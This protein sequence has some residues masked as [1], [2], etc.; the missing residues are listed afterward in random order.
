MD[1]MLPGSDTLEFDGSIILHEDGTL[2]AYIKLGKGERVTWECY[3]FEGTCYTD[4]VEQDGVT[5]MTQL[6]ADQGLFKQMVRVSELDL[7]IYSEMDFYAL[8]PTWTQTFFQEKLEAVAEMSHSFVMSKVKEFEEF[9]IGKKASV[10]ISDTLLSTFEATADVTNDFSVREHASINFD[11][12]IDIDFE[13]RNDEELY[14]FNMRI[15]SAP[16][17]SLSF[18]FG[19]SV[20]S[21]KDISCQD[22]KSAVTIYAETFEDVNV[23]VSSTCSESK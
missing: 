23:A 16:G 9:E 20:D 4:Q 3:P 2:S 22:S 13:I 19:D 14:T 10:N 21:S 6:D 5:I 17:D 15:N 11:E 8:K 18:T 7:E 12:S 1:V